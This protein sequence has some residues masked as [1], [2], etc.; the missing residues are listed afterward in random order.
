MPPCGHG[1]K[2]IFQ[3]HQLSIQDVRRIHQKYYA[4]ADTES[5]INYILQHV[6]VSSAKRSRLPEGQSRRQ[7]STHYSLQRQRQGITEH[8]QVCIKTFLVVLNESCDRVQRLC[9]K[10]TQLGVTPPETRGGVRQSHYCRGGS[11]L[12]KNLSSQLNV[13][14]MWEIYPEKHIVENLQLAHKKRANTFYRKLR[15]GSDSELVPTY[16]CQ[17]NLILPKQTILMRSPQSGSFLMATVAKMLSHWM[18]FEAP[19]HLKDIVLLHKSIV[20]NP[21]KYLQ[22]FNKFGTVTNLGK[23]CAVSDWK[24]YSQEIFKPTGNWYF[25]KSGKSIL[26]QGEPFYNFESCEPKTISKMGNFKIPDVVRGWEE[27]TKLSFYSQV[28]QQQTAANVIATARNDNDEEMDDF[29]LYDEGTE[30]C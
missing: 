10:Y 11:T 7:V 2:G 20:D 22:V 14:K 23:D 5:K 12:H 30:I 13:K 17:N 9:K 18:L 25:H 24:L 6:A 15:E 29:E 16:D 3:C 21:E 28:F 4:N 8:V 1:T 27:N 26:V 19:K